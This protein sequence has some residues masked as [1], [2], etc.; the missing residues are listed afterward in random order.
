MKVFYV[1]FGQGQYGGLLKDYVLKFILEDDAALASVETEPIGRWM[2]HEF[3]TYSNIYKDYN[4]KTFPNG[5]LGVV[6]IKDW[7]ATRWSLT[8]ERRAVPADDPPTV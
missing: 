7:L 4:E 2:Q 3:G 6:T 8:V 1:T 5:V